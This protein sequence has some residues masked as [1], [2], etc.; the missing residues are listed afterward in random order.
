MWIN[1]VLWY[2]SPVSPVIHNMKNNI[3]SAHM[4]ETVVYKQ[5]MEA[6]QTGLSW[7]VTYNCVMMIEVQTIEGGWKRCLLTRGDG[8]YKKHPLLILGPTF[9]YR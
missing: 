1:L 2:I 7:I 6:A 4:S 8:G 5:Y 3:M 9:I